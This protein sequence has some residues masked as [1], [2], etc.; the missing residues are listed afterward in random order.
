MEQG[1]PPQGSDSP[2]PDALDVEAI[3]GRRFGVWRTVDITGKS[4]TGWI[5]AGIAWPDGSSDTR[6]VNSPLG[7]ATTTHWASLEDVLKVHDHTGTTQLVWL[8]S[9]STSTI[10]VPE[11]YETGGDFI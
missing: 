4:G 11:N 6:W 3:A 9:P 8:D 2:N 1:S 5:M 10:L 7:I